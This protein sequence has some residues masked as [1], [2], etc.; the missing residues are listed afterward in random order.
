MHLF[1]WMHAYFSI[2]HI[3]IH[4][5][6]ISL[7][8]KYFACKYICFLWALLHGSSLILSASFIMCIGAVHFM[9]IFIIHFQAQNK[10]HIYLFAT[11]IY[12]QWKC[13]IPG[14]YYSDN[15]ALKYTCY[16]GM[17]LYIWYD[18][19]MSKYCYKYCY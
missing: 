17:Y 6:V 9:L 18:I 12:T 3:N 7:I 11:F 10:I 8:P 5:F 4:L 19:C 2:I 14:S 15:V 1:R 16:I 13:L